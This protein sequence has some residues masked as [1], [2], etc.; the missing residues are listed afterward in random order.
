[1]QTGPGQLPGILKEAAK[2]LRFTNGLSRLSKTRLI[3]PPRHGDR[4]AA[5]GR[6][7]EKLTTETQRTRRRSNS[8]LA[9]PKDL[10]G[11]TSVVVQR[12]EVLT[13][14]PPCLC[15]AFHLIPVRSIGITKGG[16]QRKTDT[17][18]P[19]RFIV[20][21]VCFEGLP[22]SA[23]CAMAQIRCRIRTRGEDTAG[24]AGSATRP[25]LS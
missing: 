12:K 21:L 17:D 13:Q 2:A 22:P 7:Q 10:R 16:D 25:L 3:T 9:C 5:F 15:G 24:Q 11:P 6:N 18:V 1:M 20:C 19:P 14:C 8:S 23:K 4:R